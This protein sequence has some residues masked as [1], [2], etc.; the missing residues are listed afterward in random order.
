[1]ATDNL[2][3]PGTEVELRGLRWEVIDA[4]PMGDQ[5]LVRLRGTG[6]A[7]A[8]S[9][10]DVLTPF[11]DVCPVVHQ[12]DPTRPT[13]LANWLVFHQAF[14]LEQA[15][16]PNT[17]LA[18]TPGR[19]RIEPYQLVPVSRCLRMP[20]PR[21][22]LADD[23]GLGK[24]I[25]AG[26]IITELI[27]RRRANRILIVTPAGPLLDQWKQEMAERFGLRLVV[28]DRGELDRIR[29]GAELG[30][31]PF[32]HLP[33][34]LAS[35]DY[36][37]QDRVLDWLDRSNGYDL[38]ILDEAHH[39]SDTGPEDYDRAD[40]SQRRKLALVLAK[41][42]DA[43][44]LLSATPHDGHDRSFASLLE[45]LDPSLTDGRGRV[46]E[47]VY[48]DFVVRR[49]KRHVKVTHPQTN[50]PVDFPERQVQP[51]PVVMDAGKHPDFLAA[52]RELLAFVAPELRRA[53]RS[54]R[55]DDALAYLALLKRSVSTAYALHSTVRKIRDRF[56]AL[57]NEATEEADARR[58]RI[59]TLK[60]IQRKA[61]KFGMLTPAEEEEREMMEV[62]DLAQ[63]L[64]F[65]TR[66]ER[67]R[68][69]EADH[70]GDLAEQLSRVV[71]LAGRCLDADPKIDA[72]V[73]NLKAIR[74]AE[75]NANILIYTEYADSL[76]KVQERLKAE[77]LGTVLTLQGSD[78]EPTR[79]N[80]TA[81]FRLH[82]RVLLAATDAASEGLNLHER[83]H[84]LIHLELPWNPNR[85]EQRNGRIDR[86]GQWETPI[87]RYLYLKGTFE[88]RV[89]ARLWAKYERQRSTLRFVPNTLGL[90]Q[91]E[92]PDENVLE[93]L[94]PDENAP[95]K[96]FQIVPEMKTDKP[97]FTFITQEDQP[98]DPD[99]QALLQEIDASLTRFEATVK[100]HQWLADE[101]L[102]A[103]ELDRREA[104]SARQAGQ[105]AGVVDL[106]RFVQDAVV[107]EG[108]DCHTTT[109][110]F[111]LRLPDTW[112]HGLEELPGWDAERGRM[113]ITK[114]LAILAT[115]K[116]EPV[117]FLGR[118]H[119]LVQRAID[120]VRHLA[121]G[122]KEGIDR[123]VSAAFALDGQ[124]ALVLTFL[125]RQHGRAGR[126]MEQVLGV[127]IGPN[128]QPAVLENTSDWMPD[129]DAAAPSRGV[130]DR[131]FASW[132]TQAQERAGEASH[133]AFQKIA[134]RFAREH[135]RLLDEEQRRLDDW[136]KGRADE[137]C[138]PVKDE[139]PTLFDDIAPTE[140]RTPFERLQQFFSRQQTGSK[141]RAEAESVLRFYERRRGQLQEQGELRDPEVVPLGLLMLVPR[142]ER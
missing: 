47:K 32:D 24:T 11:E 139:G 134:E 4:T 20:R 15:L 110:G 135:K 27:A 129:S 68:R 109:Y 140:P 141:A 69:R 131:H 8:G 138:G 18:V 39:Y 75:P 120:R 86:Y 93:K 14:L 132:G 48:R 64:S 66:E 1:V 5:T 16:G 96:L 82:D 29:K 136:L 31:N 78:D 114:E 10:V 62:E 85:L 103:G 49:L 128:L 81:L 61:A 25:E 79:K 102:H 36:L 45:L 88:E 9:E 107:V 115:D 92:M 100:S 123:R 37:K 125:G 50:Q 59:R 106:T 104:E 23:V 12:I 142:G 137:I 133:A 13:H 72:L 77:K 43:L 30:T 101:G 122:Q 113:R 38:V 73:E 35:M 118:A 44:L 41:A 34:A 3:L 111:D 83:C 70:A 7:F 56:Q 28:A 130:W 108:G 40:A 63:Q 76:R 52:Q 46:R 99:V 53:M 21:L 65:L 60:A 51:I 97:A 54:R 74:Q 58:N 55:Y 87:V 80:T 90:G 94:F 19:L 84:Q 17:L 124:A 95:E 105:K 67:G 42:A 116:S 33:L 126:E 91:L 98:D 26:L 112:R 6:G 57:A 127:R 89:L 119:P 121:L 71:E 117:G 2:Y 22:L